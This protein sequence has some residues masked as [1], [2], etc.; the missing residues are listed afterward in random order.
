M[1]TANS[2]THRSTWPQGPPLEALELSARKR[3]SYLQ[4][5]RET[6]LQHSL[7]RERDAFLSI[8]NRVQSLW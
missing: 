4:K 7:E 6:V 2:P 3:A 1:S 8:L 5:A